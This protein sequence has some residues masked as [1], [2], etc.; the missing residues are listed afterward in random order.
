[1][2]VASYERYGLTGNPFRDL[3]SENLED[4]EIFHVNLQIDDALRNIRDEVLDKENHAIV[5]IVG[6]LGTGK[7]E[8]LRLAL[9][10]GRARN[11][12]TLYAE[13]PPR[14][15]ELAKLIA[16][17]FQQQA[18]PRLGGFARTFSPPPWYTAVA[19]LQRL[20]ADTK[21]DAAGAG[22][23]IATALNGSAPAFL[24]LNDIHNLSAAPEAGALARLLQGLADSLRPGVLVMFG[25]YPGYW[26][27]VSK[28]Y[29]ALAS[30]INRT[31]ALPGLAHEEAALLLA[32]KLLAKRLVEDLDPTYPF[33]RE[34]IGALNEAATGNPRRLLEL[35]DLAIEYAVDHR[36][37]RVDD[38]IVRLALLSRK[39]TAVVPASAAPGTPSTKPPA[40]TNPA[41]GN[42]L[43]STVAPVPLAKGSAERTA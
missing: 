33:D 37:Y 3:A 24:L 39:P 7:T 31:F 21:F 5:G 34:A 17:Q 26:A 13:V 10:A 1:M 25:T 16:V 23:T 27:A 19:G 43:A 40:A 32:K 30:R 11:A 41:S 14:A 15:A 12:L 4:V 9:A 29:P 2:P 18:L 28:A 38:E 6:T 42:P 35:A 8:R 22:K 20:K 36:A